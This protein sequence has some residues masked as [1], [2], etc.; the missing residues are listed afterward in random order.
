[1]VQ[2]KVLRKGKK[3][4]RSPS[5]LQKCFHLKNGMQALPIALANA[6]RDNVYTDAEVTSVEKTSHGY[7]INWSHAGELKSI[8]APL[9]LSTVPAYSAAGLFSHFD[10]DLAEHLNNIYYP[11]VIA[12]YLI[13]YKKDIGHPLDGFGFLI[14]KVE[15]KSFLGALWSSVIFPNRTD[16]DKAAFTLFIG[17]SRNPEIEKYDK[18]IFLKKVISEFQELMKITSEPI[19]TADKLWHNAIPQYNTGYI[20][21]ER[22]FEQF[23]KNFP[24]LF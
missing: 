18:E 17:G 11:P 13:Y 7:K 14:P 8:E 4:R 24:G 5:S 15:K 9:V 1:L 21:H 2:L 12:L 16:D 23:E 22:Y 20:E 10:A 19:Y 6:L 3:E